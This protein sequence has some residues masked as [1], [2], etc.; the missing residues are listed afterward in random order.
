MHQLIDQENRLLEQG[1]TPKQI[2]EG[3]A[4]RKAA[5]VHRDFVLPERY[6]PVEPY[7]DLETAILKMLY[8]PKGNKTHVSDLKRNCLR[9]LKAARSLGYDTLPIKDVSARH[10]NRLFRQWEEE[11]PVSAQ[12]FNKVHAHFFSVFRALQRTEEAN[13]KRIDGAVERKVVVHRHQPMLTLE[14]IR[15]LLDHLQQVDYPFYRFLRIFYQS[16]SR[17]AELC[18]LKK[19][20][21][22]LEEHL[23]R[24]VVLKGTRPK[25]VYKPIHQSVDLLWKE[26]YELAQTG[27]YLFSYGY[28]PGKRC[29]QTTSYS[30]KFKNL[31]KDQLHITE[32]LYTMKHRKL[33]EVRKFMLTQQAMDLSEKITRQAAAHDSFRTTTLY[34]GEE[35]ELMNRILRELPSQLDDSQ[36]V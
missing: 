29:Y 13:D 6:V 16:G 14:S 22:K 3:V 33:S 7:D 11:E 12:M 17:P 1:Y 24:V 18:R 34:L 35:Q 21:V 30:K 31:V 25:E 23:Y 15:Q 20:D 2:A 4:Q 28:V 32:N 5:A 10:L 26:I 27:E 19:E 8:K 9:I 36:E